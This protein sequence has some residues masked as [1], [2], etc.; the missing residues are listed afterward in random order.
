MENNF[1]YVL[2]NFTY[3]GNIADWLYS[4][5]SFFGEEQ[6]EA[7][8]D[9]FINKHQIIR[10]NDIRNLLKSYSL[11]VYSF[12]IKEQIAFVSIYVP[13][14][15]D[16]ILIKNMEN[17]FEKAQ[18]LYRNKSIEFSKKIKKLG[19]S[20]STIW[21]N[22]KDKTTKDMYQREYVFAIYSEK[23]SL[24]EFKN[25]ILNLVKDY[26]INSVLITD[27]LEDNNPKLKIKS[28]LFDV[29]TGNVVKEFEDTTTEVLEKYFSNISNTKFVFK[30]P[31]ERNKTILYIEDN[32]IGDYYS[33]EKQ[34]KIKKVHPTG[35]NM[36]MLKQ[37][38][39]NSFSNKNYNN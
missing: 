11:S 32:T 21:G 6:T 26:N 30:I 25:N 28:K 20:Y 37:S 31:Y 18:K 33:K 34:E 2:Q 13:I 36:G 17:G 22:W 4:I 29:E 27:T 16:N 9:Y 24:E 35:F 7:F 14:N 12:S 5:K 23:D 38:L 15:K 39:L 1:N 3:G 10:V 19:Y 8:C